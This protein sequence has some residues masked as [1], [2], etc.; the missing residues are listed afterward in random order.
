MICSEGFDLF[1]LFNQVIR[2]IGYHFVE[3]KDPLS[4]AS[5]SL[6]LVLGYCQETCE[7]LLH[8]LDAAL[9]RVMCYLPNVIMPFLPFVIIVQAI[10]ELFKHIH[11]P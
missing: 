3:K 5:F 2:L 11:I 1:H 4:D 10:T 8:Q 6:Q 9:P 7:F